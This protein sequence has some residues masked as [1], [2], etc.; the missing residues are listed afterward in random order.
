MSHFYGTLKGS[1]GPASRC[2]TKQSGMTAH[3]AGWGGAVCVDLGHESDLDRYIIS[4]TPW[5][6]AGVQQQIAH[7]IVG[8]VNPSIN[9]TRELRSVIQQIVAEW[10]TSNGMRISALIID[11]ARAAISK[12]SR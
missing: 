10:D 8:R 5:E 9:I 12:A 11:E 4:L 7:G 2:G 3:A 1:R 6:G